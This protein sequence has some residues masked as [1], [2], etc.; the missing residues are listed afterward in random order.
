MVIGEEKRRGLA[1]LS[2][3]YLL[4][5]IHFWK[6]ALEKDMD[7]SLSPLPVMD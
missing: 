1:H 6:N 7:P 2:N 4:L 3:F 5:Y